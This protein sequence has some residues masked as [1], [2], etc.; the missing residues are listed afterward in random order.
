[1]TCERSDLVYVFIS[2]IC[3]EESI[4]ETGEGKTRVRVYRQHK[5][6]PH[7]RQLKCKE[8]FLTCGKGEFRIFP[9]FKL[10]SYN[11]Y[12]RE[13]YPEYFLDKFKD[14]INPYNSGIWNSQVRKL[15]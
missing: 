2:S 8:H 9:F 13:K 6:Q 4:E 12:L 7:Y 1:M 10:H 15:S 5:R 14:I 3:N 11:K